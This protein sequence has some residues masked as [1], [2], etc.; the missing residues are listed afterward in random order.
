MAPLHEIR[1]GYFIWGLEEA[2]NRFWRKSVGYT[3]STSLVSIN[4]RIRTNGENPLQFTQYTTVCWR[5]LNKAEDGSNL[6]IAK[7]YKHYQLALYKLQ[8]NGPSFNN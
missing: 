3:S 1:K 7:R 5:K 2:V 8:K 4:F 6:R